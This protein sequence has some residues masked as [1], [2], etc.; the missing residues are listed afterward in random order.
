MKKNVTVINWSGLNYGDIEIFNL[1]YKLY[2]KDSFNKVFLFA[3]SNIPFESEKQIE[4]VDRVFGIKKNWLKCIVKIAHSEKVFAGGG[5]IIR[6]EIGTLILLYI[7]TWLKKDVAICGVG[8]SEIESN[9]YTI[10]NIKSKIRKYIF[11][12]ARF[13]SV[14]DDKSFQISK[15]YTK[16]INLYKE[17]DL[18]FLYNLYSY[19]KIENKDF[20][21]ITVSIIPPSS[22]YKNKWNEEIY[23]EIAKT[24]DV[25]YEEL[26]IYPLFLPGTLEKN[27][28]ETNC[29]I[30][31][32]DLIAKNVIR[33]MKNKDKAI[34]LDH[35]PSF[36]ESSKII[37][38][39]K[40]FIGFRL[41]YI[42]TALLNKK[43]IVAFNYSNKIKGVLKTLGLE[44]YCVEIEDI[45]CRKL[46]SIIQYNILNE[47]QRTKEIDIGFMKIKDNLI[48]LD[49]KLKKFFRYE[50][51]N[52]KI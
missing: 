13:I 9:N 46:S 42:I 4:F 45:E 50:N 29:G 34:I 26:H 23:K 18:C 48:E 33:H 5:D 1:I 22:M 27:L 31:G 51:D 35:I 8:V 36:K 3:D 39:G 28:K 38:N 16:N 41:H 43:P 49:K 6:G 37:K 11:D 24:F 47:A 32:D 44:S 14:R 25:I 30:S 10:R 40:G 21:Y 7:A 12:N 20:K 19:N 15:K 17:V 52:I 2:I